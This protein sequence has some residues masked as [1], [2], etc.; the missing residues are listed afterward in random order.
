MENWEEKSNNEI[1]TLHIQMNEEYEA[2]KKEIAIL[3]TKINK[4]MKKLDDMD[5]K[6]LE[7]KKVLDSR[8]NY[9]K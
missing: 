4:F 9:S 2:T 1:I 5:S 8:L 6:Y 3:A 7:S